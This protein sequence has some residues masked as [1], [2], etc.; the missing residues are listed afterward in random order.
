VWAARGEDVAA[1]AEPLL[2]AARRRG[3]ENLSAIVWR[4]AGRLGIDETVMGRY[5]TRHIRFDLG[6]EERAGLERFREETG[7]LGLL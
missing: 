7:A 4:E 5:L 1:E 2:R 6:D 3:E